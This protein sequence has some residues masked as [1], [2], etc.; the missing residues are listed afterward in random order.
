[1][2]SETLHVVVEGKSDAAILRRL[3]PNRV[4]AKCEF[5]I[6]GGKSSAISDAR[7]LL[8]LSSEPIALVVDADTA[9]SNAI[10]QQEETLRQLLRSGPRS[11]MAEV[12][13][14]IPSLEAIMQDH[15]PVN[16]IP[17]VKR[18]VEFVER[19]MNHRVPTVKSRREVLSAAKN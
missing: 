6:A 3:L 16:Q 4:A 1:M 2:K 5:V 10:A 12:F 14:A 8:V 13:L 15:G 7:S 9:D 19:A 11:S 18:I 17:L